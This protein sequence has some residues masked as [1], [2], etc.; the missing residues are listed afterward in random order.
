VPT[1]YVSSLLRRIVRAGRVA[2]PIV[3]LGQER[4]LESL[5]LVGSEFLVGDELVVLSVFPRTAA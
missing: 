3:G 4:R 2:T 5:R 1:A